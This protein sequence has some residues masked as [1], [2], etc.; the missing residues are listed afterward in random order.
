MNSGQVS[1]LYDLEVSVW[2]CIKLCVIPKEPVPVLHCTVPVLH[3]T[4]H[5]LHC[6]VLYCTVPVLSCTAL[7]CNIPVLYFN[8][9]N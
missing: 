4:V 7:Y 6:T 5:I 1:V 8:V 3:C 9:L 2:Y